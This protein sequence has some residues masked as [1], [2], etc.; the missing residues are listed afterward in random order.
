M[1]NRY[2]SSIHS[3]VLSSAR[4][5]LESYSIFLQLQFKE[6]LFNP[7]LTIIFRAKPFFAHVC[8]TGAFNVLL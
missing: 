5:M 7:K 3:L 6:D 4:E 1:F 8:T 2:T